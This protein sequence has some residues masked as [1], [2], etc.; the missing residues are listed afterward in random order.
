MKLCRTH[1]QLLNRFL[2]PSC[3]RVQV[4]AAR[5]PAFPPL[6]SPRSQGQCRIPFDGVL[7]AAA[8]N[9]GVVLTLLQAQDPQA[10]LQGVPPLLM[11]RDEQRMVRMFHDAPKPAITPAD[12]QRM[13]LKKAKAQALARALQ[14]ARQQQA[15]TEERQRQQVQHYT[16]ER[17]MATDRDAAAEPS[18]AARA[19]SPQPMAVDDAADRTANGSAS[20]VELQQHQQQHA[21]AI[22]RTAQQSAAGAQKAKQQK[23]AHAAALRRQLIQ[24]RKEALSRRRQEEYEAEEARKHRYCR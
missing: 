7:F 10:P 4:Q 6:T 8:T 15:L 14:T 1:V 13:L 24:S 21:A 11:A 20:P 19:D 5:L 16:G 17:P 18:Q 2:L 3:F 23:E 22:S 9:S 12:F